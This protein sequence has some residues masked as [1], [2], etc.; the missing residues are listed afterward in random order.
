[1]SF[2]RSSIRTCSRPGLAVRDRSAGTWR[3]AGLLIAFF[4]LASLASSGNASAAQDSLFRSP[5][6]PANKTIG[7]HATH[8]PHGNPFLLSPHLT[9]AQ[10]VD[11]GVQQTA[12]GDPETIEDIQALEQ[13]EGESLKSYESMDPLDSEREPG[14]QLPGESEEEIPRGIRTPGRF[15]NNLDSN[16]RNSRR[17]VIVQRYAD[18]KPQIEREVVQDADGNFVNDGFWRVLSNTGERNVI[19]SG[20]YRMGVMDGV[21]QRQHTADSSGLFQTKPF[22]LFKS[23]FLSS[24]TFSNGKLDGMWTLADAYERKIFEIPYRKGQ[25][26]GTATWWYPSLNKMREVT[27]IDGVID[28]KLLEWDEQNKLTREEEFVSGQK[29]IR[30]VTFYRPKQK[31]SENFYLDPKLTTDGE[32]NW[33]EAK[34]APLVT[35]GTRLQHGPAVA[36]Y[37]NGLPKMKG[38][39]VSGK[40]VGRFTWWHNNGNKQLEG[41]YEADDKVGAWTWWHENGMKSIEGNYEANVAVGV[42]RWWEPDG[43]LASEENLSRHELPSP[44]SNSRSDSDNNESSTIELPGDEAGTNN[45]TDSTIANPQTGNATSAADQAPALDLQGLEGIDPLTD[46]GAKKEEAVKPTSNDPSL[47]PENFFNDLP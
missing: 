4:G 33:W 23:P 5:T 35:N 45:S 10:T 42:W 11:L 24:A 18:G 17:E 2:I 30:N 15:G 27:F 13:I 32:D 12:S 37:D 14:P 40:R 36:W 46:E 19:A 41:V 22:S 34:P 16:E 25:R 31:E 8:L 3:A 43:Q 20:R 26:S 9:A 44:D 38:Q 29:V 39:Y 7:D 28:G 47:L 6:L 1:M 21:W